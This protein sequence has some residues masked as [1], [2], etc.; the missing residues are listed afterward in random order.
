MDDGFKDISDSIKKYGGIEKILKNKESIQSF[1]N[2][3]PN[4]SWKSLLTF[5]IGGSFI[6]RIQGSVE[7][8]EPI[9]HT[10]SHTAM[11]IYNNEPNFVGVQE[12][13][14]LPVLKQFYHKHIS[15]YYKLP[16]EMLIDG[17]DNRG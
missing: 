2:N 1:I 3:A 14:S 7:D 8:T 6:D 15:K 9:S 11:V 4:K 16:Y 13:E 5:M 10:Q 17:N 12:I